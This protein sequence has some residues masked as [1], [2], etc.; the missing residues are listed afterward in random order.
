MLVCAQVEDL[1]L[2]M[3]K[4]EN[5]AHRLYPKLQFEDFIDKLEKLGSKKE[6]QVGYTYAICL[7][8]VSLKCLFSKL[9]LLNVID[10]SEEDTTGHAPDT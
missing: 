1:R 5:W 10:L 9:V 8:P 7:Q 3:Q 4:M 2:L 6:V